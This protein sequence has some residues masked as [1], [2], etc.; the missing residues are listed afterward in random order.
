VA[1]P[2]ADKE[3]AAARAVRDA[4]VR[5][6][7]E[8]PPTV[9]ISA[10]CHELAD[11]PRA[12]V[13]VRRVMDLL[14][15]I[16]RPG[17]VELAGELAVSRLIAASVP[18]AQAVDTARQLVGPIVE[19]DRAG[20]AELLP[21]L[22]AL[23]AEEGQVRGTARRLGVHENTVRYRMAKVRD[24]S[25]IDPHRLDSLLDLRYC[26]QILDLSGELDAPVGEVDKRS[27]Q[28]VAPPG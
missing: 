19:L 1:T 3:I 13:E 2:P 5:V 10:V 28:E 25:A 22:R 20:S 16:G 21:T 24:S 15:R 8:D 4:V 9:V 12:A 14:A 26:L 17:Q 23:L 11:Y 6:L 7:P 18:S 27:Q